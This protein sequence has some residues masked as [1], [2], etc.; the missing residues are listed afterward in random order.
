ME[1]D[2]FYISGKVKEAVFHSEEVHPRNLRNL[3]KQLKEILKI[4]L[5]TLHGFK[6][7]SKSLKKVKANKNWQPFWEW[8]SSAIREQLDTQNIEQKYINR[9]TTMSV[10]S[11]FSW[12]NS[13]L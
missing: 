11:D 10:I 6:I 3:V 13:K 5:P 8:A 12:L 2:R 9:E 7:N 1:L 4:E